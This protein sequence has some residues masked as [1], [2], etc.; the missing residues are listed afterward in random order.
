MPL[1]DP[2]FAQLNP[3]QRTMLGFLNL[4]LHSPLNLREQIPRP[5]MHRRRRGRKLLPTFKLQTSILPHS[6]DAV[7]LLAVRLRFYSNNPS[8]LVS[9][10]YLLLLLYNL[11][12][13]LAPD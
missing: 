1:E 7:P 11:L 4:S 8:I 12:T 3:T 13:Q 2:G 9:L 5:H 6:A 10:F